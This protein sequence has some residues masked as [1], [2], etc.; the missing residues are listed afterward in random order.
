[1]YLCGYSIDNLS[2]MALTVAVGFVVDDAIVMIE[3]VTRRAELGE[4]PL[5]AAL[6]GARQISFTVVSISVSL[7]AVF[8]PLLFMGGLVGRLFHE[9]AMTLSISIAVSAV[10]SLTGTPML[11]AYLAPKSQ[12]HEK[13]PAGGWF[14]RLSE[15][16]LNGM[17]NFYS[18]TL[19]IVL[20]HQWVTLLITIG[21]VVLTGYLY[22]VVPKGFFPSTGY[23]APDGDH[24]C[25]RGY[26]LSRNDDPRGRL[27]DC[28]GP[29]M[30]RFRMCRRS[31]LIRRRVRI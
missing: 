18:R 7:I 25:A 12:V 6:T 14:G 21:T 8:I 29:L 5:Q 24:G 19:D 13:G 20:R 10:V 15:G 2:L 30:N 9:F 16:V 28:R 26:F 27:A 1:M 11:C 22:V 4:T 3:N 31:V 17:V 23:R